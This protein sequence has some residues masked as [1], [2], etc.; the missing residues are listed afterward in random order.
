MGQTSLERSIQT[1]KLQVG[2]AKLTRI[3][4]IRQD[5]QDVGITP[6]IHFENIMTLASDREHWRTLI[7]QCVLTQG[8]SDVPR[9]P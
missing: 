8:D 9:F 3:N 5:L 4:P 2:R 7:R 1:N 6:D